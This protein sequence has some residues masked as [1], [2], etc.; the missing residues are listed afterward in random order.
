M[1]ALITG[2]CGLVGSA[3]TQLLCEQGWGVIGVDNDMRKQFFGAA[4]STHWMAEY[5][6]ESFPG[7]RHFPLDIR[8]R[9]RVREIFKTERPDFVIHTAGQPSHDKAA[10]I[11]YDDFDG[12][13]VGTLNLLVTAR[14]Y[15]RDSPFGFTSTNK[16]YGDN[17]NRLN[18]V[19][20]EKRY[21]Y[22]DGRD[23]IDEGM[24]ID[25]CLHSLFGA[26]KVAADV[27]CQEF[28]RYFGMPVGVFRAGCLTG[29]RHA[30]V[31]LHGYLA[32]IAWCQNWH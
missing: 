20:L 21:E 8:G 9:E 26:S 31:P 18:L 2:S 28:G 1:K 11:P 17:P 27:M 15:C 10:S 5:L 19:E 16:V 7:Y 25:N 30:A 12:N 3:C 22:A 24:S 6:C 23:G 32:Y 4:G 14:D 13:A 29:P